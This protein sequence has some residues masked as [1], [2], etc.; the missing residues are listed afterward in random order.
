MSNIAI[1]IVIF[2]YAVF[3]AVYLFLE[4][5]EKFW[6]ATT[7]KVCLSAY[8]AGVCVYAAVL[9]GN[10]VFYIFALG[11]VFAVSADYFL[12]YIKTDLK[13]YRFGIFFFGAMHVCLLVS[14]YL[15]YAISFYEFVIF[16]LLIAVLITFQMV[17]KWKM[18]KEKGQLSVY[19]V[20]VVFMA[21]K[22]IST[23]FTVPNPPAFILMLSLGG[24]FFFMSD[25]FLGIW[26][27]SKEKFVFLALNRIIYFAGQL[28]LAFYL[29]MMMS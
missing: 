29:V 28:C 9:L 1:A 22:A 3:L 21:S 14:F 15:V 18:K 8:A 20:L 13:R 12:Q 7:L 2:V 23:Y 17:G 19:T 10:Y 16:A 26:A 25:L 6:Q 27:Y 24:L 4:K 11:L 5:Q